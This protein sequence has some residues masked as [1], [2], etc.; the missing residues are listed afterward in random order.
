MALNL[1][2]WKNLPPTLNKRWLEITL[3]EQGHV[4]FFEDEVIG[5][6][7]L[8][9]TYGGKLDVYNIPIERRAYAANGYQCRRTSDDSVLCFN[10]Y[11]RRRTAATL[12]LFATRLA[13]VQRT[14]D[15]NLHKQKTPYIIRTTP[16]QELTAKNILMD[17]E[18]NEAAIMTD[19]AFNTEDFATIPLNAPYLADKL[20]IE[21]HMIWNEALTFLGIENSISQKKEREN[22]FESQSQFGSIEAFRNVMLNSR[23]EACEEVNLM[24]GWNISVEYNS[25]LITM[26]NDPESFKGKYTDKTIGEEE[27]YVGE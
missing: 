11:T 14:I 23:Q 25:D 2:K 3:Y 21:K 17:I 4:L 13:D 7:A 20:E 22:M 24:F 5:P 27:V 1:F 16:Q 19:K 26:I 10:N 15:V 18:G 6:L 12:R 8:P 9:C